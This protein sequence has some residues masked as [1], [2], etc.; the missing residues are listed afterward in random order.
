MELVLSSG[1]LAHD[2]ADDL[3]VYCH[4]NVG[5]EQVICCSDSEKALS[6][7]NFSWCMPWSIVGWITVI[8]FLCVCLVLLSSTYS[9]Y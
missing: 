9:L 8:V 7:E 2:Y 1:L 5:S 4:M 3:Q 6:V